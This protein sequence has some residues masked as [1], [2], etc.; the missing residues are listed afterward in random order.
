MHA[1]RGTSDDGAAW[2]A[3]GALGD[4]TR[5]ASSL[6]APARVP[7]YYLNTVSS[8]CRATAPTHSPPT[9]L[10][11]HVCQM[12]GAC[13][14]PEE[15]RSSS[16]GM[17]TPSNKLRF[18]GSR[19]CECDRSLKIVDADTPPSTRTGSGVGD[20]PVMSVMSRSGSRQRN[21]MLDI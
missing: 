18:V 17:P 11:T 14:F 20:F 9:S 15:N 1:V 19:R 13:V 8:C 16:R 12:M 10:W 3:R 2:L 7:S 6:P 5:S 21:A 4:P